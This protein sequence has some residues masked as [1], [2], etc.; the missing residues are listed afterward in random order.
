MSSFGIFSMKFLHWCIDMIIHGL[1]CVAQ[2]EAGETGDW[3][4]WSRDDKHNPDGICKGLSKS[5]Q[6][7]SQKQ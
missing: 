5:R 1:A 6:T 2:A 4:E 3:T 7:R